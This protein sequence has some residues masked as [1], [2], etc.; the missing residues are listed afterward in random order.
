M[1]KYLVVTSAW[2][3]VEG[4]E[5]ELILGSFEAYSDALKEEKH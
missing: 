5:V 3:S 2:D 4:K 1:E